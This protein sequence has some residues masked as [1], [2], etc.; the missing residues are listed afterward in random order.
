[1]AND[2]IS[3]AWNKMTQRNM[4]SV[5]WSLVPNCA[6]YLHSFDNVFKG[7]KHNIVEMALEVG[8]E[9]KG[10]SVGQEVLASHYRKL[11]NQEY[12]GKRRR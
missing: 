3:T 2:I 4:G 10:Q 5:W 7:N 1:M 6:H 11:T 12:K 9:E 8:F